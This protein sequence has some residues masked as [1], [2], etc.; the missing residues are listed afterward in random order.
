ML[1]SI[2]KGILNNEKDSKE[3]TVIKSKKERLMRSLSEEDFYDDNEIEE[4]GSL[5]VKRRQLKQVMKESRKM[6]WRSTEGFD[7][8]GSSSQPS[9]SRINRGLRQSTTMREAEIPAR[10]INPYM[11]P[12]KQ[13]SI[14][15]LSQTCSSGCERNWST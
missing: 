10:G 13:K 11:F 8:G 4:V 12:T 9:G 2:K 7:I 15:V 5:G 3:R 1:A 14:K 6:A